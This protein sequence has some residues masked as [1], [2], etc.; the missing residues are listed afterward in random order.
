MCQQGA[1]RYIPSMNRVIVSHD[2]CVGCGVCRHAC[3]ND[4]LKLIPREEFPG[5]RGVY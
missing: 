2:E 3:N 1:L 5:Y 4:A